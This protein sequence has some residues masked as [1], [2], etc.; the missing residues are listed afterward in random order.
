[1]YLLAPSF[2]IYAR[3]CSLAYLLNSKRLVMNLSQPN[4][5]W[6]HLATL[7]GIDYL[8]LNAVYEVNNTGAAYHNAD[9]MKA[10]AVLADSLY[11]RNCKYYEIKP[12]VVD[13][14]QLFYAS[15]LHDLGHLGSTSIKDSD[16]VRRTIELVERL[17]I[18][19]L[20]T[21]VLPAIFCTVYDR[22]TQTFPVPVPLGSP[23]AP[24][25][26]DADLLLTLVDSSGFWLNALSKE[27]GQP[28]TFESSL[29]WL[30]KQICYTY[31]GR[32]YLVNALMPLYK[33]E[34]LSYN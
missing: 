6:Q 16:N 24:F 29:K 1:M 34:V 12:N 9:H 11:M 33:D 18:D 21:H 3:V 4:N 20:H 10:V 8:V 13:R 26:R 27:T 28:M 2:R 30:R 19:S 17:G 25:L 32:Q 15:S 23:I 5:E 14:V 22:D 31:P 7:L